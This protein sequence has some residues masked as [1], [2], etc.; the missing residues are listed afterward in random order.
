MQR[1]ET[2]DRDMS[3]VMFINE[4]ATA[5]NKKPTL[6]GNIVIGG[7]KYAIAG[8]KNKSTT[9]G[10][11]YIGLKISEWEERKDKDTYQR[12]NTQPSSSVRQDTRRV[13]TK[14]TP[15]VKLGD[16]NDVFPF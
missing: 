8:W 4:N 7:V 3:G 11:T 9:T 1:N 6:S 15:S 13:V 10:K 12:G 14:P 16:D 2:A 5:E